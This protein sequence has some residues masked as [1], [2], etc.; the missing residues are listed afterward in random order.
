[1][2]DQ[3][4]IEGP[5]RDGRAGCAYCGAAGLYAGQ[6]ERH[7]RLCGPKWRELYPIKRPKSDELQKIEAA[8]EVA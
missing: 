3:D 6:I 7:R 8:L 4:G 5:Y 1:M 2:P